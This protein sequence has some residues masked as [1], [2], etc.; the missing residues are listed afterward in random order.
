MVYVP[1]LGFFR[2]TQTEGGAKKD[3][4]VLEPNLVAMKIYSNFQKN[5]QGCVWRY[6]T[7][8]LGNPESL[9]LASVGRNVLDKTDLWLKPAEP[10]LHSH[11]TQ[12]RAKGLGPRE[13][14]SH[15]E[16]SHC[17]NHYIVH[18]LTQQLIRRLDSPSIPPAMANSG[19][20]WHSWLCSVTA[21]S[22]RHW[23]FSS[24]IPWEIKN[25]NT[26]CWAERLPTSYV[27]LKFFIHVYLASHL[28]CSL[29]S[30]NEL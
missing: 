11:E 22:S 14:G 3:T 18:E 28:S 16:I 26:G 6:P 4:S 19:L 9:R 20:C 25:E 21:S 15:S 1:I 5:T 2:L 23:S 8:C 29:P 27:S 10:P 17:R 24:V 30:L 7:F 13:Q 12:A